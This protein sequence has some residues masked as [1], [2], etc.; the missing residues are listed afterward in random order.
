MKAEGKSRKLQ[1]SLHARGQS[2]PITSFDGETV[3]GTSQ[4]KTKRLFGIHILLKHV[5]DHLRM[6]HIRDLV[7]YMTQ[8]AQVAWSTSATVWTLVE[9]SRSPLM[10]NSSTNFFFRRMGDV[11]HLTTE[12]SLR[13]SKMCD[14]AKAAS[15]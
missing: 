5:F 8:L 15:Q 7:V 6:V 9:I 4:G 12:V 2:A 11:A 14:A 3:S 1:D 10:P 13:R